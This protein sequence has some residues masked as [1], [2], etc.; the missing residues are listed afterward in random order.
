MWSFLPK[1]VSFFYKEIKIIWIML[2]L[3]VLGL[4]LFWNQQAND[5]RAENITRNIAISLSNRVDSFIVDLVQDLYVLPLYEKNSLNCEHIR[6]DLEHII[7]NNPKISGLLI[8][9]ENY[10]LLCSTL[11]RTPNFFTDNVIHKHSILGPFNLAQFDQPIYLIQYKIGDYFVGI[12]VVAST[13]K[14]VLVSANAPSVILHDS[15]SK[16]NIISIQQ[17]KSQDGWIT[18]QALN[19]PTP[20]QLA[21]KKLNSVESVVLAVIKDQKMVLTTFWLSE[22]L[23]ILCT[24]LVSYFLYTLINQH[25]HHH[26]SLYRAIKNA[27]KNHHFYPEY[28]PIFDNQLN[29]YVGAEVLLR[30]QNAEKKVIMPDF[31]IEEAESSGLIVPI[32]LQIIAIAFA[33]SRKL[34]KKHP[35]FHLAFNLSVFHFKAPLFFKQFESLRETHQIAP[36]Q[37]VL[38]ITER[39]LLD[40]NDLIFKQTMHELR[41]KGYSLAVDDYGTGHASIS[42]L[43]HFPFNYLKIDKVFI[44]AIGTK[45]ITESLNDAII[46]MAKGLNLKIIAEGVETKEQFD[47]L[48]N[49]EVHLLQGWYFSKSVSIEEIQQFIQGANHETMG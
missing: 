29:H 4:A 49:N 1:F 3:L 42:Y 19:L 24:I 11:D 9:D 25:F 16:K 45:A 31:F 40:K 43:Q 10:H 32:T 15:L 34:M 12:I 2:T 27:I 44:Q 6:G 35:F 18:D 17:N 21:V 28:Q 20:S 26:Y 47:Y 41:D 33:E 30:W 37:I 36:N 46:N 22:L 14:E 48:V 5:K 7:L 23:V 39:D 38:E 8:T 13:L